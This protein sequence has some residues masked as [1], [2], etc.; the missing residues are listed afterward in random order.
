MLTLRKYVLDK[1]KT[2]I[3]SPYAT[4]VPNIPVDVWKKIVRELKSYGYIVYTNIANGQ[5]P[6]DET[7]GIMIPYENIIS[8]LNLCRG[9]IGI[10][11]GLCDILSTADCKMIVFYKGMLHNQTTLYT[12]YSLRKMGLRRDKLLEIDLEEN[13]NFI[14]SLEWMMG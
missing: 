9:F 10:R 7:E 2:I 4:S 12:L 13:I 5:E 11:S 6:I 14:D 1:R 8:C 3:V